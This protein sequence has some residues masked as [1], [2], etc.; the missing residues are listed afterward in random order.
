MSIQARSVVLDVKFQST[1][2]LAALRFQRP[3]G[4]ALLHRTGPSRFKPGGDAFL[5][6][7]PLFFQTRVDLHFFAPVGSGGFAKLIGA[8]LTPL[9]YVGGSGFPPLF[10]LFDLAFAPEKV[11]IAL[12]DA[13]NHCLALVVA[14][15]AAN[16]RFSGRSETRK[17][18]TQNYGKSPTKP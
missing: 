6:F 14:R 7:V 9:L 3:N 12:V 10:V 1:W 15:L 2:N 11:V 18:H 17:D 5:L 8:R 13:V 16:G 4:V